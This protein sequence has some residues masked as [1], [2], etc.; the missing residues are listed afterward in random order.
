[1]SK[2]FP[3]TLLLNFYQIM[4]QSNLRLRVSYRQAVLLL[5]V[6]V[7]AA[8]QVVARPGS[9]DATFGNGG[10]V[11]A[12]P[13]GIPA[14]G[15]VIQPDGK[16]VVAGATL[17]GSSQRQFNVMRY[18]PNGTL[19]TSFDGDGI[20]VTVINTNGSGEATAV[21]LQADG[22]ILVAGY[23][24]VN[25]GEIVIVRYNSDGSPD[26][27]FGAGGIVLTNP[28]ETSIPR[29]LAVQT[30]GKILIAGYR[31]PGFAFSDFLL[32]RFQTNGMLDTTF[33]TDGI[34]TTNFTN[35]P[36]ITSARDFAY[37][38]LIQPDNKIV[39][40]GS[41]YEEL[42][43]SAP[44]RV[45]LA[46]YNS[47]GSLDATFDGDGKALTAIG[48]LDGTD[49]AAALQADGKILVAASVTAT[50]SGNQN[51]QFLYDF[52]LLRYNTSGNLDSGF[53]DGGKVVTPVT[54][55]TGADFATGV[56]VQPNGRIVLAGHT[57]QNIA[58]ARFG[59]GG[60]LDTDFEFDGRVIVRGFATE[61]AVAVR[62]QADGK[63]VVVA[64]TTS[65]G[66]IVY[67]FNGEGPVMRP[68][69]FDFD[70]DHAADL[71]VVRPETNFPLSWYLNLSTNGFF[72][73]FFGPDQQKLAPADYDGDGRTDIAIYFS[74]PNP[75]MPGFN[76]LN[77]SVVVFGLT[78]DVPMPLDWDGD[79]RTDMA[80][81]RAGAQPNGQSYF[82]FRPS[83]TSYIESETL[84][85][86]INGDR[87]VPADYDGDRKADAAVFRPS[88]N[89]WYIRRSSDAQLYSF[90][91]G[92]ATDKLVPADYDGDGLA[93][94]AVYRDG[95]WFI[96][97]SQ[98][99]FQAIQFGLSTDRPTP[100][101]Y[102]ADGKADI[103]VYRDGIWYWINS[104]NNQ[105]KAVHY[106][107]ATDTPIPN[108]YVR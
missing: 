11:V 62:L 56:A 55:H 78:N 85:W 52:A 10:R 30:D 77:I 87:P 102:D 24:N 94:I 59:A 103:A 79:G 95:V 99:G 83:R 44:P 70:G 25:S 64:T 91:F 26:T 8:G 82:L 100:A 34:V 75:G 63:I 57:S 105:F 2:G 17:N 74:N 106:G 38:V 21:A 40:V 48:F 53:G 15:L 58:L 35:L 6:C 50:Y 90:F 1:M 3:I 27:S 13:N 84:A 46:R 72:H 9:L 86:G 45:A 108:V 107:L 67:R 41:S 43:Q 22:K 16:I 4:W 39:A 71:G 36:G 37:A 47:D 92:L 76:I 97:G 28:G 69:L 31:T 5:L 104:S 101:D 65:G 19:D 88:N 68:T 18:H 20:A 96:Q 49:A 80:V 7:G 60:A 54:V 73:T 51:F 42:Q 32:V 23:K 12:S 81:Y 66:W 93:D 29:A 89:A 98:N 14:K 33:D 61:R